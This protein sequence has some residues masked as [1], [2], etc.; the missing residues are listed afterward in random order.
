MKI[1]KSTL[2]GW[3]NG[4]HLPHPSNVRRWAETLGVRTE[5]LAVG[6]EPMRSGLG[7]DDYR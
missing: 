4:R 1:P 7:I 2:S 3:E 6:T 5:W